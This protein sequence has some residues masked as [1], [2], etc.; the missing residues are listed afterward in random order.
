MS[1]YFDVVVFGV[2]FGGY[3]VVICVV[4]F[5]K[6]IVIIEKE[7]W[8]GVCFNVGCIFIKL[9]LCNVEL[10]YIVI[11]EVK[12]F[13]IGGDIIVD[14]GK[15]F[16]CFCEV[17]VCMVKG[18][19]FFMKKNKIIE[20]NGWGEFIGFKVIFVKDFDGKVI[21]EIIFDNVIIVV[22]L[23]VKILL[24]IQFFGWVVIYKEQIFFDIVFGFIVIVGFGV[25]GIEFVYVLVNYGC[26]VIIV[27]FFDCMVLNEDKEVLVELVKVYKKFGIKVLIFIKVDFIDDFGDKVKVIILLLKGGEFKVIEVDCVL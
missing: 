11:K 9:F 20:F 4:Q 13:G 7:Y 1:L 21:D 25:I 6:K 3:V 18:I 26:D 16:S 24:G 2:G 17:F 10:V 27:E 19:Y 8:G 12:I 15:V 22:G 5:G 14:F 23:V